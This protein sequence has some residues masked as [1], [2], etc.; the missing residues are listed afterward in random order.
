MGSAEDDIASYTKVY[1]DNAAAGQTEINAKSKS[2]KWGAK[3]ASGN[4]LFRFEKWN[5]P[6][7]GD[8][9]MLDPQWQPPERFIRVEDGQKTTVK[10]RFYDNGRK[11]ELQIAREP[12]GK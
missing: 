11:F 8:W 3:L 9:Q 10:A 6:P 4:H 5:L 1:V 12:L 7:T 2:K